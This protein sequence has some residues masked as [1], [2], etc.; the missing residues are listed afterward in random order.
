MNRDEI[1]KDLIKRKRS[2]TENV[3][4]R[5]NR[6]N[7]SLGIPLF[8]R[9]TFKGYLLIGEKFSG[10]IFTYN[11]EEEIVILQT[12]IENALQN[13]TNIKINREHKENIDM[14]KAFRQIWL[15][16]GKSDSI[17][18]RFM[19]LLDADI[20]DL[21]DHLRHAVSLAK[22]KDVPID[23]SRLFNDIRWWDASREDHRYVLD[24]FNRG[25]KPLPQPTS[26]KVIY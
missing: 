19:S 12:E 4:T 22:S 11:D 6:F 14:G 24:R 2:L 20:E 8:L 3:Y 16:Y 15:S 10:D 17:E 23:W 5:M 9:T 25:Y 7:Y 21:S 13:I 18:K 1:E 26:P